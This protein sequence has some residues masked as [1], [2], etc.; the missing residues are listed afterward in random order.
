MTEEKA[1]VPSEVTV[2][3]YVLLYQAA[4]HALER[5]CEEPEGSTFGCMNAIIGSAFALEAYFNDLGAHLFDYWAKIERSL[6]PHQKLIVI[7]H[8]LEFFDLDF[9]SRPFQ[10]VRTLLRIRNKLAHGTTEA[11]SEEWSEASEDESIRK[12]E[13]EWQKLCVPDATTPLYED[14][15]KVIEFLHEKANRGHHPLSTQSEGFTT[16]GAQ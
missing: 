2:Y 12:A 7:S 11:V 4:R 10:S 3:A 13:P 15:R 1:R 14:V 6:T 16:K 8:E 9:G 5:A